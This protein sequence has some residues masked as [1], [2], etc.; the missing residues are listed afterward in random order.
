MPRTPKTAEQASR[1]NAAK[2][3]RLHLE[4]M[5][6]WLGASMVADPQ[7]ADL[8]RTRKEDH[9]LRLCAQGRG[10]MAELEARHAREAEAYR[11]ALKEAA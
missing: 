7:A 6:L 8:T 2:F 11:R 5:P 10:R 3:N 1:D 4:Q 9:Q